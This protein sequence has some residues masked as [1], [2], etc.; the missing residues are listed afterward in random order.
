LPAGFFSGLL[1]T[2]P[3]S[4]IGTR[5]RRGHDAGS[6]AAVAAFTA[7]LRDILETPL[8]TGDNP[9]ELAPVCLPLS[10]AAKELLWRFYQAVET[11]QGAGRPMEQARAYASKAAEQA[12]RIAGVLTLWANVE[13]PE[14]TPE[15]MGWGVKLAQFYLSEAKQLAEAGLVSEETAK[16]ETLRKWLL[17]SWEDDDVLP[18]DILKHGPNAMRERKTLSGPLAM[19][20]KAGH[21]IQMDAGTVIRGRPRKEAYRIVRASDD[22]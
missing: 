4:L 21:L 18:S 8:P 13:A 1:I 16:A 11:A 14:V 7:R 15:A 3:P 19:L 2:E 20:V 6:D 5:L 12:A 9:Q 10:F 22:D 17:E